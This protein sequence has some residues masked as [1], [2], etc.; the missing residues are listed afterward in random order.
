MYMRLQPPVNFRL[1]EPHISPDYQPA[2]YLISVHTMSGTNPPAS[3]GLPPSAAATA[4]AAASA[5][6][7]LKRSVQAAFEG[8]LILVTLLFAAWYTLAFSSAPDLC[9]PR[10]E[11]LIV[12]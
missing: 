4:R 3:A 11:A 12:L 9:M 8:Q 2:L 1:T 10:S 5:T 7:Q 6:H